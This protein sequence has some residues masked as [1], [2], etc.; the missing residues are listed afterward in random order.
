MDLVDQQ[1]LHLPPSAMGG[2][3]IRCQWPHLTPAL[4]GELYSYKNYKGKVGLLPVSN[5]LLQ[6]HKKYYSN[7]HHII[8]TG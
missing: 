8:L 7:P 6:Q 3:S 1:A 2:S 4:D 5:I